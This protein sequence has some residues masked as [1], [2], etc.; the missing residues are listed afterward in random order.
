MWSIYLKH[1]S[2]QKFMQKGNINHTCRN[3]LDK[4]NFQCD[5]DYG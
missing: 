2:I 5:M 4:A 3:D 1:E